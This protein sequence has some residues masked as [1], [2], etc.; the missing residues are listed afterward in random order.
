MYRKKP[1]KVRLK[2]PRTWKDRGSL[3]VFIFGGIFLLWYELCHILPTYYPD[4]SQNEFLEI[5]SHIFCAAFFAINIYGNMFKL[6]TTE[7]SR[8]RFHFFSGSLLPEGWRYCHDCDM[9]L[10][11]RSHHCKLCDI[12]I[13]KR[14]H[15]CWFAGYCIGYHNHRYYVAMVFHMVCAGLYCNIFNLT[16]V[17]SV[18]GT[19]TLYTFMSYF[20]PHAGWMFGYNDKY[21]MA[22]T[23][24]TT[25]GTAL[26]FIFSMMLFTQIRQIIYGQT[27]HEMKKEIYIYNQGVSRNF[28]E[29]LG[30]R[31]YLV[32]LFPWIPSPLYGDGV[33]FHVKAD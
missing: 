7:T 9:N 22:I 27:Q 4:D 14:D 1:I 33:L 18:K 11:P 12:C 19:L 30:K 31:W 15:H 13:L 20:A 23:A 24:L 25:V 21:V 16:F 32:L 5:Y 10:P 28:L 29:V 8:E 17:V 26:L 6:V 3:L 2:L